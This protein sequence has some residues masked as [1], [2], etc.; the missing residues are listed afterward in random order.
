MI[1][2]ISKIPI[3]AIIEAIFIIISCTAEGQSS[4]PEKPNILCIIADDLGYGDISFRGTADIRTPSIDEISRTGMVFNNFYANCPVCSPSR[5]SL[6]TGRY[7]D[8][9]GVPGVIRQWE[10]LNWGY[11]SESA[12]L[13]PE[14]LK[15][16]GYHTAI[17]GK[18]HLGLES[19]NLPN[20]RG[21]DYFH[22]FLA[23]M[24][25]D[26]WTHRRDG[27]N[28]MRLNNEEIDPRGHATD[29]YTAWAID[30]LEE[31]KKD[32]KPFFL[33]LAHN[34]P[35][36]PIQ[37]PDEFLERVKARESGISDK[38]ARIVA[39]IEHLDESVGKVMQT[40]EKT[41]LAENTLVVFTSDNGGALMF[42]A[43]NGP[44][45][46]G[47]GEMYEGGIRVPTAFKWDGVIEPG[48]HTDKV[49]LLMDL[50]PTFCE[51]AGAEIGYEIDG[52]SIIPTLLGKYQDM[53]ERT[54]FWVRF[55]NSFSKT[56]IFLSH[57]IE[58][59]STTN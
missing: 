42:E 46:G 59:R 3:A 58:S 23:A 10:E 18:W 11:L 48:S 21:F 32:G 12:V 6:L 13:I 40:L 29:L 2:I 39:F 14:L 1:N 57:S 9:V 26:Y 7:P 38:R 17:I 50:F 41:G 54:V 22:G 24:M 52:I 47:K 51:L 5:A 19:P 45:R 8:M 43:N 36:N 53:E 27:V 56:T 4:F 25:D 44:L 34:A 35:H 30:Y 28:W 16:Q 31:R 49:A 37:P 15:K 33:Y 55:F 20:E